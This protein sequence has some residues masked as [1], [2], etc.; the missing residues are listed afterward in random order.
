MKR[1]FSRKT[2]KKTQIKLTPKE[3]QNIIEKEFSDSKGNK[4]KFRFDFNPHPINDPTI[5]F[6][7]KHGEKQ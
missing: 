3:S 6:D 2:Q 5:Q 7:V 4:L 1:F